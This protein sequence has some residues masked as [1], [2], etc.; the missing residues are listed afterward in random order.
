MYESDFQHAHQKF[1]WLKNLWNWKVRVF[2]WR[3]VIAFHSHPLDIKRVPWKIANWKIAKI[4][5]NKREKPA[6]YPGEKKFSEYVHIFLLFL[7]RFDFSPFFELTNF[8]LHGQRTERKTRFFVGRK[9]FWWIVADM[10]EI[11]NN[12][13]NEERVEGSRYY[14]YQGKHRIENM[15]PKNTEEKIILHEK[16]K[17][18]KS[19]IENAQSP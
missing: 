9:W 4:E 18:R 1:V 7:F 11:S 16:Y 10:M 14:R 2:P 17:K 15:N 8:R 3:T 19:K 13:H 5:N 12:W 6:K